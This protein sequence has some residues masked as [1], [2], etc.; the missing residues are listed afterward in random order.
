MLGPG[1]FCRA[2]CKTPTR[3]ALLL[4]LILTVPVAVPADHASAA[5]ISSTNWWP[6]DG[7]AA[8][9]AGNQPGTLVNGTAFVAGKVG[10]AFSFDGVDDIVRFGNVAGDVGT[11]D[12]TLSFWIRTSSSGREQGVIGKRPVC[13][14]ASFLD[15]RVT[16]TGRLGIELD[17]SSSGSNYAYLG[18]NAA[19]NDGVF[20]HVA[21]VRKGTTASL[22]LDGGLDKVITTAGVANIDNDAALIAGKSACTGSDGTAYFTGMLDEIVIGADDDGDG[23]PDEVDNCPVVANGTQE[24]GDADG[25]G[26]ACE[27][28]GAAISTT[29]RWPAEG[30][31]NDVSGIEHGT[32]LNG[33]AYTS[34][35]S[36]QAFSFD[37]VND[38]VGFGKVAGNV[39]IADFT[40]AFWISTSSSGRQEAIVSKRASCT[41]AS[42]LDLRLT[43][44]GRVLAELGSDRGVDYTFLL[45]RSAINDGSFHHVA[46][47]RKGR[48]ARLLVDGVREAD[49][50]TGR[51]SNVDTDASLIA[52]KGPCIGADG[53]AYF[54]GALDEIVIGSDRDGDGHPN[55]LD[56]CPEDIN[57]L[58]EDPD[59][60]GVG[61]VCEPPVV[62]PDSQAFLDAAGGN[63]VIGASSFTAAQ[64]C[65]FQ[66]MPTFSVVSAQ[67]TICEEQYEMV[68]ACQRFFFTAPASEPPVVDDDDPSVMP[69][70]PGWSWEGGPGSQP[71]DSLGAWH[72]RLTGESMHPEYGTHALPPTHKGD[73]WDWIDG[74]GGKWERPR[75]GKVWYPKGQVWWK[76]ENYLGL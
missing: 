5:D 70:G 72:R 28:V 26:D 7:T 63:C 66:L 19:V 6:G 16:P 73:H 33:T 9:S 52:G 22:I 43:P 29:H 35:H 58:Q 76:F 53:T 14:H 61:D 49:A 55:L 4:A 50:S 36:G 64:S 37:G 65:M 62:V 59:G 51:A 32:L 39:G 24:D 1:L 31:A 15:V 67:V 12:F 11:A 71:G 44:A 25:T 8:D 10:Q 23:R 3:G 2:F 27:V 75:G 47:V 41:H 57:G 18:S 38:Y 69:E 45:S 17:G 68:I 54:K 74:R 20:H 56:N 46:L 30:N 21:L 34:G 60:D 13:G 48:V 40:L 42:M